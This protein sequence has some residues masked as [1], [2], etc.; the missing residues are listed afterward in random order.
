MIK[1]EKRLNMNIE[2]VLRVAY[3][4]DNK[5]IAKIGDDLGL[6]YV[7]IINWLLLSGIYSRNLNIKNKGGEIN[8]RI[9]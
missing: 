3:V 5:S 8:D 2:E 4:D 9:I 6:S 7:T 1:I